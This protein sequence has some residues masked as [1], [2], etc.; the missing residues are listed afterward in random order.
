[1]YFDAD[2]KGND[3]EL[4]WT[5]SQE[6]NADKFNVQRSLDGERFETIGTV[7]ATGNS[8]TKI[9]YAYT[10]ENIN[11][12]LGRAYYRIQS[13]DFDGRSQVWTVRTVKFRPDAYSIN[14]IPNPAQ[15]VVNINIAALV[16]ANTTL[17][18]YN[19]MGQQVYNKNF[20]SDVNNATNFEIN[21]NGYAKGLYQVVVRSGNNIASQKLVVK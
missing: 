11:Q 20:T 19:T 5:T 8:N 17:S 1:L 12:N 13:M 10:D 14:L 21:L 9:E 4:T 16:N 3:V 7:K 2:L 15:D 6:Q 18:I